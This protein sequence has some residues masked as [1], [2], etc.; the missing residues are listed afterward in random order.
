MQKPLGQG[1]EK[2]YAMAR[3]GGS[4]GTNMAGKCCNYLL[5]MSSGFMPR[6]SKHLSSLIRMSFE[7]DMTSNVEM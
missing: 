3:L 5:K 6:I 7:C 1:S 2:D 4:V